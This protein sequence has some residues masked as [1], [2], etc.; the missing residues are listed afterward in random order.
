MIIACDMAAE[1]S[2]PEL[3]PWRPIET[4]PKDGKEILAKRHIGPYT[5]YGTCSWRE[6]RRGD[7]V[8]DDNKVHWRDMASGRHFS[9]THWM[10]IP[11]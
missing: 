9:P 3:G 5:V 6:H 10:A 8:P 1:M 11:E 7:D 4:A 2:R